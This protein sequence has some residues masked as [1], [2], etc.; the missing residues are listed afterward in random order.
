MNISIVL[1]LVKP[2]KIPR[3]MIVDIRMMTIRA[4]M[5]SKTMQTAIGVRRRMV[6]SGNMTH[7][8]RRVVREV[9]KMCTFGSFDMSCP[10]PWRASC[11]CD[12]SRITD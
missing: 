8:V 7:R 10:R 6:I 4:V 12:P 2:D 1:A 11:Q 9:E 3:N 5:L